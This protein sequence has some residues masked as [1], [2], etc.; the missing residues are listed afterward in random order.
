MRLWGGRFQGGTDPAMEA[1]GRSLESDGRLA[2]YDLRACRAHVQMLQEAGVLDGSRL[3]PAL[4]ALEQDLEEGRI[5]VEGPFEDVHSWVEA[6]LAE[7]VGEES[8][9]IR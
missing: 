3:L 6:V 4:A 7:R 1:F 8:S 5:A 2:P 9:A